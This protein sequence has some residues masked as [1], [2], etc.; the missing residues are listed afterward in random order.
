VS[1]ASKRT[2]L[3]WLPD[4]ERASR[5]TSALIVISSWIT[6]RDAQNRETIPE[7]AA[8]NGAYLRLTPQWVRE[9]PS[10]LY[11]GRRD[12]A[13][14]ER[15]PSQYLGDTGNY[16][17]VTLRSFAVTSSQPATSPKTLFPRSTP[18]NHA[19]YAPL[20]IS[21]VVLSTLRIRAISI[22]WTSALSCSDL[23][24]WERDMTPEA[25]TSVDLRRSPRRHGVADSISHS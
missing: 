8:L 19:R 6:C 5:Q 21:A 22:N 23:F 1:Y 18:T 4:R 24:W 17:L 7:Q 12:E 15:L 9:C 20:R 3:L 2:Q 13:K 10:P 25:R 14:A 11:P 16:A